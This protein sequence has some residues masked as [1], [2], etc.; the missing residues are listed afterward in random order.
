MPGLPACPSIAALCSVAAPQPSQ[1]SRLCGSTVGGDL[2]WLL[3]WGAGVRG[4]GWAG[5][6]AGTH[7]RHRLAGC[8]WVLWQWDAVLPCAASFGDKMPWMGSGQAQGA[9]GHPC[10]R[11]S[12]LAVPPGITRVQGGHGRAALPGAAPGQGRASGQQGADISPG[13]RCC[14]ASGSRCTVPH[15]SQ[16]DTPQLKLPTLWQGHQPIFKA[17]RS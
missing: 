14:W 9:P 8:C 12:A 3:F 2:K 10:P 4:R 7:S 1:P 15:A 17:W 11:S 6:G 13:R 16:R 5:Q